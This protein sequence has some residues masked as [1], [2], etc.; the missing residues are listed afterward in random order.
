MLILALDTSLHR[1]SVAIMRGEEPLSVAIED[2]ERGHAERLAPMVAAALQEAGVQPQALD[3]IGVVVGPGGFA[4]VRIALSFARAF[5]LAADVDVVGVTSLGALAGAAATKGMVAGVID[6]RRGQVYAALFED[7]QEILPPFI[8]A[9]DEAMAILSAKAG[10]ASV[11]VIGSG[12]T[13]IAKP[14]RWSQSNASDQIDPVIVARLAANA[15]APDGPPPPLYLR[16]PDA[17]PPAVRGIAAKN[18]ASENTQSPALKI[19]RAHRDEGD[20]LQRLEHA[21]FGE[22]GWGPNGLRGSFDAADVEILLCG[23]ERATPTGFALWRRLPGEAEILTIGTDPAAQ[24]RGGARALLA[25]VIEAARVAGAASLFLEVNAG[26]ARAIALYNSVGFAEIARRNAY[27][28][29]G[30]D[31]ILMKKQL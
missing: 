11:S 14:A 10:D 8:A 1:C 24:R 3:R 15:P 17:K 16:P 23:E 6:A 9:L 21:A 26:N 28:R 30:A 27:Y 13:L 22:A 7:G 12:A 19:W 31:A 18:A 4:G 25:H 20:K 2:M 29:D 5:G